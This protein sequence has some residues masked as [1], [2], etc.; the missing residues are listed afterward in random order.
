MASALAGSYFEWDCKEH[1][2]EAVK[3]AV[4]EIPT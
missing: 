4:C 1:L 2:T 3:E